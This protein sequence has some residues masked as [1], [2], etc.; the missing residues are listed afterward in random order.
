MIYYFV[1]YGINARGA[2]SSQEEAHS[3]AKRMEPIKINGYT[4]FPKV[5]PME[6]SEYDGVVSAK[7]W[8]AEA[9]IGRVILYEN[10]KLKH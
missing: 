1:G 8:Y 4:V 5:T 10:E 9:P 2:F 3:W 6:A 7:H